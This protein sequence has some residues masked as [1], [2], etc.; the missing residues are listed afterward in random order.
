MPETPD[1][2]YIFDTHPFLEWVGKRAL[3]PFPADGNTLDCAELSAELLAEL[4]EL[5]LAADEPAPTGARLVTVSTVTGAAR[6]LRAYASANAG[7]MGRDRN[8]LTVTPMTA[9]F[10]ADL[11]ELP[12]AGFLMVAEQAG[13]ARARELGEVIGE[14]DDGTCPISSAVTEALLEVGPWA[15]IDGDGDVAS[16]LAD[17]VRQMGRWY[18]FGRRLVAYVTRMED[19]PFDEDTAVALTR[20]RLELAELFEAIERRDPLVPEVRVSTVA[21]AIGYEMLRHDGRPVDQGD[22]GGRI[23][24]TD[25]EA[26]RCRAA[27]IR[28]LAHLYGDDEP[29]EPHPGESWA[30]VGMRRLDPTAT[31]AIVSPDGDARILGAGTIE[32]TLGDGTG[33]ALPPYDPAHPEQ[34]WKPAEPRARRWDGTA[35]GAT[36]VIDWVLERGGTASF[37]DRTDGEWRIRVN[38]DRFGV[39]LVR[40]GDW[41][42]DNGHTAGD[43]G[44]G[45][46]TIKT[47]KATTGERPRGAE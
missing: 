28:V 7:R 23:A 6:C 39:A 9:Q 12:L 24:V 36:G 1:R 21:N 46:W 22:R 31:V 25:E 30:D 37:D 26:E 18:D 27:A 4:D 41:L 45:R 11:L 16:V 5:N 29:T 43:G 40:P 15:E 19:G 34:E 33:E 8:G 2:P 35:A 13:A 38:I 3:P 14:C 44:A 10:V 32:R 47:P 42:V 20:T 17:H